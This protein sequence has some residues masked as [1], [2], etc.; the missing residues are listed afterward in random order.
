MLQIRESQ[1]AHTTATTPVPAEKHTDDKVTAAEQT[2]VQPVTA[3][4]H[5]EE[6]VTAEKHT[7]ET[8]VTA[9]KGFVTPRN[10]NEF[11]C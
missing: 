3:T 4:L 2:I 11:V 7:A 8:P 6:L 5:T 1:P 10:Q 9:D